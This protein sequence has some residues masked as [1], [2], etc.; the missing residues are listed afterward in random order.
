MVGKNSDLI[1]PHFNKGRITARYYGKCSSPETCRI[2]YRVNTLKVFQR[3]MVLDI[4]KLIEIVLDIKEE[5]FDRCNKF[6]WVHPASRIT[7]VLNGD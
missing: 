2:E 5:Q 3:D 4:N 1:L 6:E 7:Y